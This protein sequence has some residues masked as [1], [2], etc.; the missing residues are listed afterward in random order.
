MMNHITS[1][2]NRVLFVASFGLAGLAVWEKLAN[3]SG[4]TVLGGAYEPGRLLELSGIALL[5]VIAL[6]LREVKYSLLAKKGG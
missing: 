3:L 5:F 4:Y 6:L 1:V 2:I